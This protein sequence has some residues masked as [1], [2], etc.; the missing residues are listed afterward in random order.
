MAT[1]FSGTDMSELHDN[2]P[3][4]AYYLSLIVNYKDPENWIAKVAVC[5]QTKTEGTRKVEGN[6]KTVTTWSASNGIIEEETPLS[7]EETIDETKL[8]LY[9]IDCNLDIP[10]SSVSVNDEFKERVKE[11]GK[12]KYAKYSFQ[13]RETNAV[14]NATVGRS[15]GRSLISGRTVHSMGN[16]SLFPEGDENFPM[17]GDMDDAEIEKKAR[18][19]NAFDALA[20]KSFLPKLLSQRL[21]CAEDFGSIFIA[22][23]SFSEVE[24]EK[25]L[26]Q[27]ETQFE[28]FVDKHFMINGDYIDNHA[29]SLSC[30]DVIMPFKSTKFYKGISQILQ[31]YILPDNVV[32]KA[33]TKYLTG[34]DLTEYD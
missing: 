28:K 11:I 3:N 17:I 14:A 15:V 7:Q 9:T 8:L 10:R 20:V 19:K 27:I 4:H 24:L 16:L 13:N 23:Q 30:L 1:F 32:S 2:A 33:M 26:D 21:D 29:I 5:G 25:R 18:P 34:I 31:A 12:P 6:I 22:V